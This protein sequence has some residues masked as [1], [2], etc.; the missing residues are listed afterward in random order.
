MAN[1]KGDNLTRRRNL[2]LTPADDDKLMEDAAIAGISVSE[3][4]RRRYHGKAVSSNTDQAMLRELRRLGGLLKLATVES[5][6]A[7]SADVAKA[8]NALE[9]AFRKLS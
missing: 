9:I 5:N 1:N 6:G 2:R 7:Y 3:M 4:I 8:M